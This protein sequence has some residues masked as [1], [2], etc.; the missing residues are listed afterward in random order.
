MLLNGRRFPVAGRV[1]MD[2]VVLDV[3]DH[4]VAVGDRVVMF[5]PGT[6][7]EPTAEEWADWAKTIGDEIVA[8]VGHRVQRVYRNERDS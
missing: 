2:Q 8:R 1:A 3:G 4:P 6:E 7:G 5:G